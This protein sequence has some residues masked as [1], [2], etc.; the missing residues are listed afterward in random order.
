MSHHH[1]IIQTPMPFPRLPIAVAPW[2]QRPW[3]QNNWW[4]IFL[5]ETL[6]IF[7]TFCALLVCYLRFVRTPGKRIT[8]DK[9]GSDGF[10]HY[11]SVVDASELGGSQ[12]SAS[13]L[14]TTK[15]SLD[16]EAEVGLVERRRMRMEDLSGED[17]SKRCPVL[18]KSQK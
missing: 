9:I 18:K 10:S 6:L 3:L 1:D 2:G 4:V 7:A 17:A 13:S 15:R 14:S 12:H 8:E 16:S 5:V 11:G